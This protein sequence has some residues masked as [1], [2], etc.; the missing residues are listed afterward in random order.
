MLKPNI[1]LFAQL[2]S[3]N[4]INSDSLPS[5]AC[6]KVMQFMSL[7]H[8]HDSIA[9]RM[10]LSSAFRTLHFTCMNKNKENPT[11]KRT[12]GMLQVLEEWPAEHILGKETAEKSHNDQCQGRATSPAELTESVPA[13]WGHSLRKAIF[14]HKMCGRVLLKALK[15]LWAWYTG[16]RSFSWTENICWVQEPDLSHQPLVQAYLAKPCLFQQIINETQCCIFIFHFFQFIKLFC[17]LNTPFA[18][19]HIV[20]IHL[21][22]TY[23]TFLN[24]PTKFSIETIW[25]SFLCASY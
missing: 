24:L 25:H 17:L 21:Q 6:S 14:G 23:N 3:L 20:Q 19:G 11:K 4:N 2:G 15:D 8:C 16:N 18:K 12:S 22:K 13:E 1:L 5:C 10:S 7:Q 9:A